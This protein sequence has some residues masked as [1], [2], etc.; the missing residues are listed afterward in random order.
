MPGSAQSSSTICQ[1]FS[2]PRNGANTSVRSVASTTSPA[3]RITPKLVP[4]EKPMAM[5][6]NTRGNFSGRKESWRMEYTAGAYADSP[7]PTPARARKNCVNVFAKPQS[8]V[9]RLQ[10]AM[11]MAMMTRRLLRS[12]SRA[13]GSPSTA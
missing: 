7:A 10:N 11:P 4:Y 6:A 13:M 12:A 3:P 1:G 2:T 9:M 5:M 8:A